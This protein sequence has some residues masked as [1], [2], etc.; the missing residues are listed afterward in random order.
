MELIGGI[1]GQVIASLNV[2]ALVAAHLVVRLNERKR[3]Q[4][5]REK[6]MQSKQRQLRE[7]MYRRA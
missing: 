7:K 5:E 4:I 6:R 3:K 1:L 2:V